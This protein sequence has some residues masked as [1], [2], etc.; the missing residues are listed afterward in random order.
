[1]LWSGSPRCIGTPDEFCQFGYAGNRWHL[2]C[3]DVEP[4]A[5]CHE[6]TGLFGITMY[7]ALMQ[8]RATSGRLLSLLLRHSIVYFA[9]GVGK[10]R[11]PSVLK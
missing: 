7:R 2:P 3:R 10:R 4:I 11:L 1:M 5:Y 8:Y 6:F 9:A